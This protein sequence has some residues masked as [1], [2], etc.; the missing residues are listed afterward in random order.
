MMIY[1]VVMNHNGHKNGLFV[2]N[3]KA[4]TQKVQQIA[5]LRTSY[6]T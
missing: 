6:R 3:S 4:G 5:L 1:F 2:S